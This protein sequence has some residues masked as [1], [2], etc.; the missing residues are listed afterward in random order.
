MPKISWRKFSRMAVKSRT[1]WKFSP[2]KVSRYTVLLI[3]LGQETEVIKPYHRCMLSKPRV[4][5]TAYHAPQLCSWTV[6][7][8]KNCDSSKIKYHSSG[9]DLPYAARKANELER[10][11]A[12]AWDR[13]YYSHVTQNVVLHHLLY[14]YS[15]HKLA[16][17]TIMRAGDQKLMTSLE[18]P[19]LYRSGWLIN[20]VSVLWQ[21]DCL[22]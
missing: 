10:S 19:Y 12:Y 15:P 8:K 7:V 21:H 1:S 13:E 17:Q 2:S 11:C 18:W 4:Q 6:Q 5:T 20:S 14:Y 3:E 9:F 22:V 16:F